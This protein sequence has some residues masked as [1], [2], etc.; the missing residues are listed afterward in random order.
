M[1][2]ADLHV[3]SY[4][5]DGTFSP[6]QIVEEARR[7]GLY[8]VAITDHDN[9]DALGPAR[10]AAGDDFEIIPG[11][12]ITAEAAGQEIHILAYLIDVTDPEFLKAVVEMQRIR[13]ER[14]RGI[15]R[16]LQALGAPLE[17]EEV[18]RLAAKGTVGRL[19]V[20]RA[21]CAK[22]FVTCVGE[23]F[24]RFIGDKGPAYVGKF[25]MTPKEAIQW[26]IKFRG[27]PVLAHPYILSDKTLISDFV[28]AGIMGLEVFYTEHSP[29]QTQEFLKIAA[30]H[31]LLVTGG[32]DCHGAAKEET[33][34]GRVKLPYEYVEKLKWAQAQLK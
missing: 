9:I 23:A 29:Y 30:K 1:R 22:G 31:D 2:Y 15:C 12:E 13:V 5:S 21:L 14:I 7:A 17:A 32:S 27:V 25:K 3:H 16:K 10:E 19:H 6:R 20:A 34:L 8:C 24:T 11:I 26:V 33:S 18:F 4:F 28:K